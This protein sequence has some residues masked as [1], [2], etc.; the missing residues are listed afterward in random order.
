MSCRYYNGGKCSYNR[1][2]PP[3]SIQQKYCRN[4]DGVG[5]PDHPD[6]RYMPNYE[7]M[8]R[9]YDAENERQR[10]IRRNESQT[11]GCMGVVAILFILA[12]LYH[13]GINILGV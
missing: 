9:R 6:A 11:N 8:D 7:K 1:Y 4:R 2:V 10:N 13:F 3:K 12:L 5:C